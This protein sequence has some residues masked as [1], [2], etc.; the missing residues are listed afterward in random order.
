M[1]IIARLFLGLSALEDNNI[2]VV[3]LGKQGRETTL[4]T[5]L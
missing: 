2:C 5:K 1:V 3:Y 4:K